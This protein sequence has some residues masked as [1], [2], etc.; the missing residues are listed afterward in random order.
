MKVKA[1]I[2]QIIK[3]EEKHKF[4]FSMD[5]GETPVDMLHIG[6][7]ERE[8]DWHDRSLMGLFKG[9]I[10]KDKPIFKYN[11]MVFH[12]DTGRGVRYQGIPILVERPNNYEVGDVI[13]LSLEVEKLKND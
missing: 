7:Q 2:F 11:N 8:G 3:W 12:Q 9:L 1:T 13:E 5:F 6:V 4:F 10:G